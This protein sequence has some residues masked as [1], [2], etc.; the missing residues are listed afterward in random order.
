MSR[1]FGTRTPDTAEARKKTRIAGGILFVAILCSLVSNLIGTYGGPA[2][3][4]RPLLFTGVGLL[5]VGVVY[6]IMNRRAR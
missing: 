3:L 5:A 1:Q 6:M 2:Q 4:V